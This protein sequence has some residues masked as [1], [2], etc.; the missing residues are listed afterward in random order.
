MRAKE[1]RLRENYEVER[2]KKERY[3]KLD[4]TE[5][6]NLELFKRLNVLKIHFNEREERTKLYFIKET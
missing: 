3:C 4:K 6:T 1:K 5:R 2:G